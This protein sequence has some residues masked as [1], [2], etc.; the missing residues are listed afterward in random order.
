VGI[1]VTDPLGILV[2]PLPHL[3][4]KSKN[5][6]LKQLKSIVEEKRVE[7][8]VL[9]LPRSLDGTLGP[10]ALKCQKFGEDLK[11]ALDVHVEL[12]DESFTS[13]QADDILINELGLSRE[14]RKDLKDSLAACLILKSH[15]R[16]P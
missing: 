11:S 2:Q 15:L 10:Q 3:K 14:K 5:D 12:E 16:I 8:I 9:G 1:A 6:L 13:R 4:F 7:K